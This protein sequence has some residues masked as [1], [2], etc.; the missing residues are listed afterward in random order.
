V[1]HLRLP[2]R[3]QHILLALSG[4]SGTMRSQFAALA[5][6]PKRPITEAGT[7]TGGSGSIGMDRL[8]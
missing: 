4:P 3:D 8:S 5:T 2:R 7:V 1:I 6:L